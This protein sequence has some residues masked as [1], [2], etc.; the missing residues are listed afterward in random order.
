M[1]A[2]R[3]KALPPLLVLWSCV[4]VPGLR[5]QT[6][7]GESAA[8]RTD[9]GWQWIE[10]FAGSSSTEGQILALTSSAGYN[11]SSHVGLVAGIPVY[12]VHNPSSTAGTTSVNGIGDIFAGLRLSLA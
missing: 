8:E 5:A 12:F 9:I 2:L 4:F 11:F 7:A 1:P 3:C 6:P 10:Q